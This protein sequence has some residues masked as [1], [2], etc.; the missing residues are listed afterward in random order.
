[1]PEIFCVE[2]GVEIFHK[3]DNT[4]PDDEVTCEACELAIDDPWEE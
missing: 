4:V 2:C 1:M 3:H